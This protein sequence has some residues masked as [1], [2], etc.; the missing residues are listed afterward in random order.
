M[1]GGP[2]SPRRSWRL[3][4]K[5][6]HIICRWSQRAW[7]G[8]QRSRRRNQPARGRR[9]CSHLRGQRAEDRGLCS[10]RW[11]RI[12]RARGPL[13]LRTWRS[14]LKLAW[15]SCALGSGGAVICPGRTVVITWRGRSQVGCAG[16]ASPTMQA[17]WIR[18]GCLLWKRSGDGSGSAR[19]AVAAL[20]GTA[21]QAKVSHLRDAPTPGAQR[22]TLPWS[23]APRMRGSRTATRPG[24]SNGCD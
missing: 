24:W 23:A 4:Q 3:G 21:G 7:T 6:G 9:T 15:R 10:C 11:S 22:R 18:S 16:F 5:S 19:L 14:T 1:E 20:P 12:A 2:R 17:S 13:K 8:R